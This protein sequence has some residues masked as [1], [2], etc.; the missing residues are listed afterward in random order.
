MS[1]AWTMFTPWFASQVLFDRRGSKRLDR[2]PRYE[3]YQIVCWSGTANTCFSMAW[4]LAIS[5]F[6]FVSFSFKCV[7]FSSIASDGSHRSTVSSPRQIA[8]DV[9][10]Q[11][12]AR[13]STS[14]FVK[15][16]SRL[17]T[18][19]KLLPSMATDACRAF[20]GAF[21]DAI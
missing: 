21:L 10:F 6:S 19:L 16:L 18:A 7:F 8:R 12:R 5:D 4:S 14:A 1:A 13:R 2:S 15:F 17:L 9:L 3:H 11:L 20:R